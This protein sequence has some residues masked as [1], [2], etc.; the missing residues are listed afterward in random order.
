MQRIAAT[1]EITLIERSAGRRVHWGA[2]FGGWLVA[3]GIAYVL[4]TA[5]LAI[6]FTAI[7][8]QAAA[9][10]EGVGIG[11]AIWVAL[12]WIVSLFLG[13]M[14]AAWFDGSADDTTG[15]LHGVIV[16]GLA[17]TATG[18]L[19]ALGVT[20]PLQSSSALLGAEQELNVAAETM[21][22]YTAAAFWVLCISTLLGLIAAAVGGYLGSHQVERLYRAHLE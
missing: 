10:A 6:G 2:V 12:T 16:W 22:E 19:M 20:Q 5:G 8:T 15:T 17:V 9:S 21:A 11:T 1:E 7:D 13:G 4:Y 3:A 14:F 18:L